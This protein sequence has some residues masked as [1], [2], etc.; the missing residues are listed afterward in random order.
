M[1]DYEITHLR[2]MLAKAIRR[3][4]KVRRQDR[5][6]DTDFGIAFGRA[7][8]LDFMLGTTMYSDVVERAITRRS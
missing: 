8:S 4:R 3:Y 7:I 6:A 2:T 1:T 5:P